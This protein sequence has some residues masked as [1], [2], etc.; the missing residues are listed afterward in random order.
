MTRLQAGQSDDHGLIPDSGWEF[1]TLI[2]C[3]D[4]LWGPPS[5]LSSG[6]GGSFLGDK[7]AGVW[8]WPLTYI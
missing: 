7:V 3:P 4:W 1:F 8:S 5:L 2:P 6:Y